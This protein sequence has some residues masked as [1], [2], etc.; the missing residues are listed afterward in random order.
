MP[1]PWWQDT[2]DLAEAAKAIH[3]ID[4]TVLRLL[5]T[6]LPQAPGG[7]VTYVA[8]LTDPPPPGTRPDTDPAWTQPHPKRMPWANPG[9]PANS[10]AWAAHVLADQGHHVTGKQQL[11][12]WNLSSIWR[13]DTTRGPF[14][15]KEVPPF[16]HHEAAVL[17]WLNGSTTPHLV[18]ANQGRQLLADIPG[19]DRYHAPTA[20]RAEMLHH[21][22]DIQDDATPEL[23]AHGVPDRRTPALIDSIRTTIDTAP[24]PHQR[25]EALYQLADELHEL[26]D[27]G[28]P[29]TLIHGDFHPG[30]VRTHDGHHVIL[31]WGDSAIANPAWD[32]IRMRDDDT[33]LTAQWCTHWHH[34]APGSNPGRAAELAATLAPL[35]D[36]ATYQAFLD[37]IEPTEH[38]YHAADVTDALAAALQTSPHA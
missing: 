33:T 25:R 17:H 16:M 13:L 31:D 29:D 3:Q 21:L 5:D 24:L 20:D 22:L 36:A 4:I 15:L 19:T 18:A 26:D 37:A 34:T 11:R 27:Q 23:L 28:I 12:T 38:P 10:L 35:R 32:L 7:A 14:W 8:E 9:G 1:T 2:T 6:E 30:N